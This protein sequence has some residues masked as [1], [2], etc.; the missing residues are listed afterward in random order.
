MLPGS[1]ESVV[2]LSPKV[3]VPPFLVDGATTL[4][5]AALNPAADDDEPELEPELPLLPLLPPQAAS[6]SAAV[7]ASAASPMVLGLLMR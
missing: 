3:S 7:A 1:V 4:V 6:A 5:I 2:L